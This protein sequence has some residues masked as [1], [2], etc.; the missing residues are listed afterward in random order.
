MQVSEE[1]VDAWCRAL[2]DASRPFPTF[3]QCVDAIPSLD[4]LADLPPGTRVLVRCD[5]NVAFGPDGRLESDARLVSLL[6]TLRF[7]RDRGWVQIV[8]GHVG[9]DGRESLRPVA[10]HLGRLLGRGV[11]FLGDWMDDRTGE[12]HAAAGEAVRGLAPGAVAMLENARR[13]PL[14][15]CLWKPRPASLAPLLG[16]LTR[17]ARTVR[18]RLAAVHV[19]EG[20]AASNRDLSSALVPLAMDRVALGRHV[21]R[22]L[23]G[24]VRAARQAEIVVFSGAKFNKL[25]D[26]EAVVRRGRVRLVLSGG[27][28]ALPL[29]R[30]DA[31]LAGRTFEVG[32]PEEVPAQRIDQARGLLRE[33][34]RRGVELLLPADFVLED[35]R[36]VEAIPAGCAQ[37]D[38]G[39][40]TLERFER[41]LAA[42]ASERPGAVVFHNGVLGQFERPPFEEG[43]RRLLAT[44]HRLHA[45][46]L[47][48]YVG[49]GEGGTALERLGDPR[50]VTHRFTGG[51]TIL[52]ALGD[53]LI[54]YVKS[55]Y[56]AAT[57]PSSTE[58]AHAV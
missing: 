12:V 33:M 47:R 29:L 48:V 46:G 41:R 16:R 8:H 22:E 25:D 15:L 23:R 45:A 50:R 27:L 28:L 56:L 9:V 42:F 51:T 39:P 30:A 3:E 43:T 34:R 40:R 58:P 11:S 49:G 6:D 26:L 54:P 7:G 32:R 55:L 52:K 35:G 38:V 19:N 53:D 24:P 5:T 14:E 18:E 21:A 20:F 4:T 44:L 57:R 2:L 37:R 13:Y 17:Y 31:E 10:E 36:V 1:T